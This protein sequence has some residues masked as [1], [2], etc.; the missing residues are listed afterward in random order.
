MFRTPGHI[1]GIVDVFSS[2]EKGH[3]TASSHL[4]GMV[5]STT[6]SRDGVLLGQSAGTCLGSFAVPASPGTYTLSCTATRIMP[7]TVLGTSANVT[8]TFQ[9]AGPAEQRPL[10]LL[11]VRAKGEVDLLNQA[12]AGRVHPL[13]LRVERQPGSAS[14]A[15]TDLDLEVSFD[16]GA[17]WRQVPVL[18]LP[19]SDQGLAL[20]RHPA[21]AGFVS[22]RARASDSRGNSVDQTMIR[23]YQAVPR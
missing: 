13:H 1:E 11:S 14:A 2:N 6:L 21:A 22:L 9:D 5:A 23:A 4:P 8:W 18:R 15:I 10:P 20:Y 17:T 16:D 3:T 12:A 7:H 19:F